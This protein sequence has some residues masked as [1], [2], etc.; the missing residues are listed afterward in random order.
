MP[1]VIAS[2]CSPG[3][4]V[5]GATRLRRVSATPFPGQATL[6]ETDTGALNTVYTPNTGNPMTSKIR[7]IAPQRPLPR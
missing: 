6:H 1:H 3:A 4:P 2:G 7:K 5:G